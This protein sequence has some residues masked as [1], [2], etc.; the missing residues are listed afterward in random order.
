LN[1]LIIEENWMQHVMEPRFV[2][3]LIG[4]P[5]ALIC[6]CDCNVDYLQALHVTGKPYKSGQ[7]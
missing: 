4:F 6:H 7:W 5:I 3:P 1:N 2:V